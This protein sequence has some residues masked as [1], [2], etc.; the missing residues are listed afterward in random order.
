MGGKCVLLAL[1]LF[2]IQNTCELAKERAL[3]VIQ[4]IM[5]KDVRLEASSQL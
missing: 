2:L 5:S 1:D 4:R 3:L